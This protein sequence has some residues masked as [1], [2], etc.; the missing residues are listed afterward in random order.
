[1]FDVKFEQLSQERQSFLAALF[2]FDRSILTALAELL[3]SDDVALIDGLMH[4]FLEMDRGHRIRFLV[5]RLIELLP[6]QVKRA[7]A[8][9]PPDNLSEALSQEPPPLR[10]IASALLADTPLPAATES[11]LDAHAKGAILSSLIAELGVHEI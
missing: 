3:P 1:M 7:A 10:E 5:S 9:I 6:T 4:D 11:L 8:L 2:I